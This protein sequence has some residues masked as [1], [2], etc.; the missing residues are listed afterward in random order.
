MTQSK[1]PA[2][3]KG[4]PKPPPE[5][6]FPIER[7]EPNTVEL[8]AILA[9][10]SAV[11]IRPGLIGAVIDHESA[12]TWHPLIKPAKAGTP[13][14]RVS[15]SGRL[16]VDAA[17]NATGIAQY[18]D[19]TWALGIFQNGEELIKLAGLDKENPQAAATIRAAQAVMK[20]DPDLNKGRQDWD[21][22]FRYCKANC[23][24]PEMKALLDLRSDPTGR[25]PV[26]MLAIDLRGYREQVEAEGL[27]PNATNIYTLHFMSMGMLKDMLNKP[28]TR[29]GELP[30]YQD[31]AEA[32]PGVFG[33]AGSFRT[34]A[35]IYA[36]KATKV[37]D[38][39]AAKFERNY[40]GRDFSLSSQ[41]KATR[42]VIG[43]D[44]SK[45]EVRTAL[46][47]PQISTD[48]FSKIWKSPN[49]SVA[50][51]DKLASTTQ[52]LEKLG[53]KFTKGRPPN[54]Q[55]HPPQNFDDPR[56]KQ[57][58]SSFK[59]Y[60]GLPNPEG[61][62]DAA[63][64]PYLQQAVQLADKYATLQAK[65][66]AA[67][68]PDGLDDLKLADRELQRKPKDD[69]ERLAGEQS[70]RTIRDNLTYQGFLPPLKKGKVQS[71]RVDNQLI[72][73]ISAFQLSQGMI[74]S[75][76]R[77]DPVTHTIIL[78]AKPQ[79]QPERRS[80]LEGEGP[81]MATAPAYDFNTLASGEQVQLAGLT[82]VDPD[83]AT[84]APDSA[85][86]SRP[87]PRQTLG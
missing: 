5:K 18:T 22:F 48:E 31:A 61:G 71:S 26:F 53:Y 52:M 51:P 47:M 19:A 42:T 7:R 55:P 20:A 67:L 58:L 64:L 81:V 14:A 3:A 17:S 76:G 86:R 28:S 59:Q 74:D 46:V 38:A 80:A 1:T 50:T 41:A 13:F 63:T 57:Y 49:P 16:V 6:L 70:I 23:D 79:T 44:G 35:E 54:E 24:K 32:N 82:T 37:S 4:P 2:K 10:S 34:G 11:G 62:L 69:P 84:P 39:H 75:K 60:V 45:A 73:A 85:P 40:Y 15:E 43:A 87:T 9:A 33:A 77:Y 30:R 56:L 78:N 72:Q 36:D 66:K 25:V 83:A 12:G 65:Q 68:R 21:K 29:L 27:A 8:A